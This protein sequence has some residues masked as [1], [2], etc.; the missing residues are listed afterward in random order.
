MSNEKIIPVDEL[1]S[2]LNDFTE[3]SEFQLKREKQPRKKR[4]L[5][6]RIQFFKSIIHHLKASK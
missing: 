4:S 2:E 1:I 5:E 3:D 6:Y